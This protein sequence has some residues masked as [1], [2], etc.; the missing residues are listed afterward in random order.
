MTSFLAM[1][2][3]NIKMTVRNRA[4]LFWNL[5]FP[6]IFIVMFGAVFGNDAISQF[7]VGIAGADTPFRAAFASL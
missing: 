2:L 1:T 5:A 4:A 7:T 3:A 6:A